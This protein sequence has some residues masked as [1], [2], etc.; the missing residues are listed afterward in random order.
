MGGKEGRGSPGVACCCCYSRGPP[1]G[2]PGEAR[3]GGRGATEGST[4]THTAV[5]RLANLFACGLVGWLVDQLVGWQVSSLVDI[6]S[7]LIGSIYARYMYY[8]HHT[9]ILHMP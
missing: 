5:S 1:A 8:T 6:E 9:T 3:E 7:C 2:G 4:C